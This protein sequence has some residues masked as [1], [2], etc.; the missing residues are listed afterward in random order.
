[1]SIPLWAM[2]LLALA[3]AVIAIVFHVAMI[4]RGRRL[5][6]RRDLYLENHVLEER[7]YVLYVPVHFRIACHSYSSL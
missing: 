3:I 7:W 2:I 1:M 6:G 5:F 4:D